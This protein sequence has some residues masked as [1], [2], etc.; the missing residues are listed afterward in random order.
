ML[1]TGETPAAPSSRVARSSDS[2]R[3]HKAVSLIE[4][5]AE[6]EVTTVARTAAAAAS[7]TENT[8]TKKGSNFKRC[9]PSSLKKINFLTEGKRPGCFFSEKIY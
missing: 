4:D 5:E 2:G 3:R 6:T 7:R 1:F 8:A 9:R